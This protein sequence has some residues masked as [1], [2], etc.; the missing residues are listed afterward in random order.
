MIISKCTHK[1]NILVFTSLLFL[2]NMI[3][4]LY[5]HYYDYALLFML[6]TI[7]SVIVHTNEFN[8]YINLI[9]KISVAGIVL[10]GGYLLY[11]KMPIDNRII[12]ICIYVTFILSIW[13]YIYGYITKQYC[14]HPEESIYLFYHGF[15]HLISSI[16]HHLII[17]Y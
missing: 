3:A 4:A 5:K 2:T 1:N 14:F 9:D 17:F 15:M 10:Y 8:I 7:T 11:Q 12:M 16:G 6:L 13:L